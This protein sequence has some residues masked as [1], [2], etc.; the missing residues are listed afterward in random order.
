MGLST[1]DLS[2]MLLQ[3]F[4]QNDTPRRF[5]FILSTY[6]Y[7]DDK[8]MYKTDTVITTNNVMSS[9][10]LF[11]EIAEMYSQINRTDDDEDDDD[12]MDYDDDE[13]DWPWVD[14]EDDEWYKNN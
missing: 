10:M 2:I 3:S 13:D 7:D 9:E 4:V 14:N 5:G 8:E 1:A 11:R 6:E 12:D